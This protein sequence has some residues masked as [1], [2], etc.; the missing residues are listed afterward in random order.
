MQQGTLPLGRIAAIGAA[1]GLVGA[2]LIDAYLL[3][4]VVGLFH[5][6]TVGGFYRYV[7]SGA[8][9]HTAFTNPSAVGLGVIFHLLI[10]IGWG[11]GFCWVAAT[12]VQVRTRPL[13]SGIVFGFVV[14]I[15]MQI[16]EVAANIYRLP[17]SFSLANAIVAHVLFFGIPV[18]YVVDRFAQPQAIRAT[19]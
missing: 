7:A 11:V 17:N 6:T 18:A 13:V 10:G 14:M 19:R 2:L 15:A 3:V 12:T 9:G 4:T 5:A 1:A 8:L 16:V